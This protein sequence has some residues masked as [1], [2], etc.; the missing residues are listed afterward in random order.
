MASH[1]EEELVKLFLFFS[2][3]STVLLVYLGRKKH[4]MGVVN[5]HLLSKHLKE[6]HILKT[7]KLASLNSKCVLFFRVRRLKPH[8]IEIENMCA[9]L[10]AKQAKRKKHK[11]NRS[12]REY[13]FHTKVTPYSK[14]DLHSR[15]GL[16]DPQNSFSSFAFT[17][18]AS[19]KCAEEPENLTGETCAMQ[20]I[21]YHTVLNSHRKKTPTNFKIN[22]SSPIVKP[23]CLS[24]AGNVQEDPG[25]LPL[26]CM[27]SAQREREP[28]PDTDSQAGPS[29]GNKSSTC[30]FHRKSGPFPTSAHS[31][32]EVSSP[33]Q[34]RLS[35]LL[36][37]TS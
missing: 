16:Q 24:A 18:P 20:S 29:P 34:L 11:I 6:Q 32:R 37:T 7:W 26:P 10:M 21:Y 14:T 15:N 23:S 3:R 33:F 30:L 22:T 35:W 1:T 28:S 9:S 36:E 19:P 12:R 4:A 17:Y 2:A 5:F 13:A 8:H 31:Q 27:S 25:V